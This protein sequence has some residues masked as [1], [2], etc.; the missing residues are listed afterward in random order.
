[1]AMGLRMSSLI[2]SRTVGASCTNGPRLGRIRQGLPAL[3]HIGK[4][5]NQGLD[6]PHPGIAA[7]TVDQLS[8]ERL[9]YARL[10]GDCA[11]TG[12]PGL[13]EPPL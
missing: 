12:R 7:I 9:R 4:K 3:I 6:R 10:G 11:P 1:M 13:T 5:A 2:T 8:R